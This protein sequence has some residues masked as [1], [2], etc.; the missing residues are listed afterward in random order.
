MVAVIA[1]KLLVPIS[2][3]AVLLTFPAEISS[4]CCATISWITLIASQFCSPHHSCPYPKRSPMVVLDS[5]IERT[6]SFC[7]AY[8]CSMLLK[9]LN[10]DAVGH[11]MILTANFGYL[12]SPLS[13]FE[14]T[15]K[16]HFRYFDHHHHSSQTTSHQTLL[17]LKSNKLRRS[18]QDVEQQTPR[19]PPQQYCFQIW[20]PSQ[21]HR[22]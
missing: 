18:S 21:T 19:Q 2:A 5:T 13:N 17:Q 10:H 9:N 15:S 6:H 4:H 20:Q 1:S 11:V 22:C 14:L 16:I 8:R 12:F 3:I 7:F